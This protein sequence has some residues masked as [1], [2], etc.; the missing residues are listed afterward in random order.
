MKNFYLSCSAAALI[1]CFQSVSF[2][3]ECNALL[4][5]GLRNIRVTKSAEASLVAKYNQFCKINYDNQSEAVKAHIDV[6]VF[7][8]GAGNAGMSSEKKKE[9]LNHW[10]AENRERAESSKAMYDEVQ[11]FYKDAVEAWNR[12]N[13]LKGY[14][15]QMTPKITPDAKTLA[16]SLRYTGPTKSGVLYMGV[17][18]DGFKCEDTYPTD[19]EGY[20]PVPKRQRVEISPQAIKIHCKRDDAKREEKDGTTFYR[21]R[22]GTVTIRTAGDDLQLFFAEE[23]VPSLPDQQAA[24]L[25]SALD[26]LQQRIS[27]SN[28]KLKN[29]LDSVRNDLN[30]KIVT[31]ESLI[32][33]VSDRVSAT[34]QQPKFKWKLGNNGSVTC[35]TYCNGSHWEGFSG[36]CVSAIKDAH[37]P[38]SCSVAYGGTTHCLCSA[39]P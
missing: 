17:E 31:N 7:G 36:E 9:T 4:S 33:G 32:R 13:E 24:A 28:N 20:K 1:V 30:S 2:A 22:E 39:R 27:E 35:Q 14:H 34:E 21:L 15:V 38:A 37:T 29:S 12:C 25:R 6:E 18:A 19:A 10:C 8:S 11:E 23:W 16:V 3:E 5:H 26:N